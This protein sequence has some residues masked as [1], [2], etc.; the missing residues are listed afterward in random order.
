MI[1]A[2]PVLL[3]R[4]YRFF[5]QLTLTSFNH[6]KYLRV[7]LCCSWLGNDPPFGPL[8]WIDLAQVA[9]QG[10]P[11]HMLLQ[12]KSSVLF[13]PLTEWIYSFL[14]QRKGLIADKQQKT[15]INLFLFSSSQLLPYLQS[16]LTGFKH[17]EILNFRNGSVVVNSRMKLDK[18]VPYNVTE[19]VHCVLEDFCSAASKRLD[20]E[21]DSR[22]L[23]IEPGEL[24]LLYRNNFVFCF[25]FLNWIIFF[26]IRRVLT[27]DAEQN[28]LSF[29]A[30][31]CAF[32]QGQ[33]SCP[34]HVSS[35]WWCRIDAS[36]CL[37]EFWTL[38]DL[39]IHTLLKADT[40]VHINQNGL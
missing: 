17:L 2:A 36:Y 10:T 38:F 23:E 9:F 6:P 4:E 33:S 13:Q 1:S 27:H 26:P 22:S 11:Y 3:S 30:V 14:M 35:L 37:G 20:I 21:I 25:L 19:A 31:S 16:N 29:L 8:N 40:W 39:I 5:W 24:S 12:H 18:P 32:M 15:N 7:N 28:P 34:H